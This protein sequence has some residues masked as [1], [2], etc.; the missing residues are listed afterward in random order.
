MGLK[1]ERVKRD[2]YAVDV[3]LKISTRAIGGVLTGRLF[4][5]NEAAEESLIN[6]LKPL[7]VLTVAKE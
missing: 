5:I 4:F 7:G 3:E 1:T 2:H 6:A